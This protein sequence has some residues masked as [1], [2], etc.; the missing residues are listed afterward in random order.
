MLSSSSYDG[1]AVAEVSTACISLAPESQ[2]SGLNNTV[3]VMGDRSCWLGALSPSESNGCAWAGIGRDP[4]SGPSFRP[5]TTPPPKA[6]TLVLPG[7]LPEPPPGLPAACPEN[8]FSAQ[9]PV[10][11]FLQKHKAEQ[12]SP[13]LKSLQWPHLHGVGAQGPVMVHKAPLRPP[14]PTPLPPHWPLCCSVSHQ[15]HPL[16]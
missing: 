1:A 5:C 6:S 2:Q 13:L 12:V 7:W 9:R 11:S 14:F 4:E 16:R 15:L 10:G 8:L 3:G